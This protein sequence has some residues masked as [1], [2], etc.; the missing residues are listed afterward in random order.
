MQLSHPVHLPSPHQ[1]GQDYHTFWKALHSPK[2]V[3]VISQ[4]LFLRIFQIWVKSV[5]IVSFGESYKH[6]NMEL[7]VAMPPTINNP[8]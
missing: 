1:R 8:M 2:G 3:F 6:M 4:E 5:F 7:L